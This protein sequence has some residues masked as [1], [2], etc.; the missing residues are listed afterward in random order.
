MGLLPFQFLAFSWFLA[1]TKGQKISKEIFGILNSSQKNKTKKQYPE[2]SRDNMF[3]FFVHFLEE[4]RIPEI[5]FEIYWP[6][7]I[8]KKTFLDVLKK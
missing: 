3:L 5:A 2:S 8:K 6:L 1:L 4:L 7:E